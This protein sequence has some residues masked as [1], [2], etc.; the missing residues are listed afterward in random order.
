MKR[1]EGERGNKYL[2][3]SFCGDVTKR[4]IPYYKGR[5]G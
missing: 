4:E 5:E 2:K 1:E 3:K